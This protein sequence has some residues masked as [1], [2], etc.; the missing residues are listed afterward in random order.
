MDG[1][2]ERDDSLVPIEKF[3]NIDGD[4]PSPKFHGAVLA[5]VILAFDVMDEDRLPVMISG[6][7]AI[8]RQRIDGST[9][10]LRVIKIECDLDTDCERLVHLFGDKLGWCD[11]PRAY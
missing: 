7:G 4:G 2:F 5:D 11:W 9:T 8:H 10:L 6:M 3:F 1:F